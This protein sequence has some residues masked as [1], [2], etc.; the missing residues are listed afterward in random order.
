MNTIEQ[1]FDFDILFIQLDFKDEEEIYFPTSALALASFIEKKGFSAEIFDFNYSRFHRKQF[2]YSALETIPNCKGNIYGISVYYSQLLQAL[3]TARFL[4]KRDPMSTIVFGGPGV[5]GLEAEILSRFH[6][7]V[8]F[9][10]SG[11]GEITLVE[12]LNSLKSSRGNHKNISGLWSY[13]TF[14]KKV[15]SSSKRELI[16][17]VDNLPFLN[18]SLIPIATYLKHSK[19]QYMPIIAGAG[20]PF[21]CTFC[22]TSKFWGRKFRLKSPSRL[23]EEMNSAFD[24]YGIDN[25]ALVHDNI[26]PSRKY[27]EE[28]LD[29]FIKSNHSF[30]W[31]GAIRLDTITSDLVHKMEKAGCNQ[32]TIGIET[33]SPDLQKIIGK[34]LKFDHAYQ[35][36]YSFNNTPIQIVVS[37]IADLP[38]ELD[39]QLEETFF[40]MFKLG[41]GGS[42]HLQ[43][44]PIAFLPATDIYGQRKNHTRR[45]P[46][47]FSSFINQLVRFFPKSVY[48][49]QQFGDLSFFE[50]LN[51]I[52]Q[53]YQSFT[54]QNDKHK[55][56][57]MALMM[58]YGSITADT[59]VSDLIQYEWSCLLAEK[60]LGHTTSQYITNIFQPIGAKQFTL[61]RGNLDLETLEKQIQLNQQLTTTIEKENYLIL[62]ECDRIEHIQIS[63]KLLNILNSIDLNLSLFKNLLINTIFSDNNMLGNLLSIDSSEIRLL[64][65]YKLFT[66]SV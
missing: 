37:F 29:S 36:L 58:V 2:F 13:D 38:G 56:V 32:L 28:L 3:K 48:F 25:F 14:N 42:F 49:I 27:A 20:C 40:M 26:M 5:F 54:D 23:L 65:D 24:K 51:T 33:A 64:K 18:Y 8:D 9:L 22:S 44:N 1:N 4:K 30:K 43:L 41:A 7:Y 10:V 52:Y 50:L 12:L 57:E 6:P 34:R 46:Q 35:L 53:H 66:R 17:E 19:M 63:D 55:Q 21:D 59:F 16:P 62:F 11:E 15:V 60:K 45:V 39:A 47:N 61:F 31:S